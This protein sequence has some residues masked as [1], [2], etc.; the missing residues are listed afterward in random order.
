MKG[1]KVGRL[2]TVATGEQIRGIA[3]NELTD[4]KNWIGDGGFLGDAR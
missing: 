3:S 2:V 4:T 1:F